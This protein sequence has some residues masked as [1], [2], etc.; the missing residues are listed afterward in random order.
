[1]LSFSATCRLPLCAQRGSM[2]AA[3]KRQCDLRRRPYQVHTA[4]YRG[5]PYRVTE[6]GKAGSRCAERSR[7]GAAAGGNTGRGAGERCHAGNLLQGAAEP[8]Q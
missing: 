4:P 2:A 1:M 5:K 3:A 8:V 7:P 6:T